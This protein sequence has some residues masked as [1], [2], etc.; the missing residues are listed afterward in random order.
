MFSAL[1]TGCHSW[2]LGLL[3]ARQRQ[4][5]SPWLAAV[6]E[7]CGSQLLRS[8]DLPC[9]IAPQLLLSSKVEASDLGL[10]QVFG[11]THV[12]NAAGSMGRSNLD[13]EAAGIQYLE[14]HGEDE[15]DY[16]ML[17]NHFEQASA[18][19]R[20]AA[21]AGGRCLVHCVA[22]INRSGVLVAAQLM[23]SERL[24]VLEAV[25]RCQRARGRILWNESFQEQLVVLAEQ[26][27]LLGCRPDGNATLGPAKPARKPAAAALARL[28]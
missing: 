4:R 7:L 11:V 9:E 14:L 21:A 6:R 12:L 3:K 27:G 5:L 16:P 15:E 17:K 20:A 22:G 25:A 8:A 10:L 19:M 2:I 1:L 24:S 18:F 28:L 23:V 13:L 26:E